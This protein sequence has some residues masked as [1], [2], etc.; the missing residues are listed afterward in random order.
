LERITVWGRDPARAQAFA[1]ALQAELGLPVA[2][3]SDVREAVAV[4]DIVTT[5]TAASEPVLEGAWLA[6]GAHVNVVGSSRAGP[7]EVDNDLVARARYIADYRA[8]VL[9]QGAEFLRAKAA[10]LVDDSHVVGEI[11][12]VLAGDIPGRQSPDQITAY[13]SLGHIV[14]DLAAVEALRRDDPA[15]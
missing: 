3:A 8:G 9:A 11:G 2:A 15:G 10:G 1:E 12:Q 4:A 13:K 7:V 5:V 6:P 14:Q